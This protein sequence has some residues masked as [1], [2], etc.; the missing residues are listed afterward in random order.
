[1]GKKPPAVAISTSHKRTHARS[2]ARALEDGEAAA[3][4]NEPRQ[5]VAE[6]AEEHSRRLLAAAAAEGVHG[7]AGAAQTAG[8][9]YHGGRDYEDDAAQRQQV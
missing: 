3:L 2:D 5:S 6:A 4:C 9:T 7:A 1:M 8:T